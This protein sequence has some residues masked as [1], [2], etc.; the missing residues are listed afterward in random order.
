VRRLAPE[1]PED[2]ERVPIKDILNMQCRAV[3]VA[4]MVGRLTYG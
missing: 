1:Y 3:T 4:G 2:Y